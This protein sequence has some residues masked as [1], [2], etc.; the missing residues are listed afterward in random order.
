MKIEIIG[1][2]SEGN[3]IMFCGSVLLDIGL[4]FKDIE[5]F[6]KDIKLVLLTHIHGDHFNK[7]AIRKLH[8]E[9]S[10]IKFCCGE[11]LVNE[12]TALG[13]S[14]KSVITLERGKLYNFGDI[15]FSPIQLYHDVPNFGYRI[16]DGKHKHIHATDTSTLDG[17][18]AKDYDTATIECNHELEAA[19]AII[20]E[21]MNAGE[22][23]HLKRAIATHL[24][25][26]KA[27]EFARMNSIK[28]LYPVHIGGST[29]DSIR[30]K[31][32]DS[33]LNIATGMCGWRD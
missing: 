25:A 11:F 2:G 20:N 30:V 31:L 13:V 18:N 27:I 23:C 9:N 24:S 14:E 29:I 6:V 21:K 10:G 8:V 7:A 1:T 4:P 32:E 3:A 33:G 28:M 16:F 12:I 17:I 19:T 26:D 5:P 15:R 22:F